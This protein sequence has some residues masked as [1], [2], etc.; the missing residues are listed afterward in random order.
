MNKAVAVKPRIL[1]SI[2]NFKKVKNYK[3]FIQFN[4]MIEI[5]SKVKKE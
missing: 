4:L 5:F 2:K 3:N 1:T